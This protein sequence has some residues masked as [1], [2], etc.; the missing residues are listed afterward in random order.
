MYVKN[1]TILKNFVGVIHPFEQLFPPI[2]K[3]YFNL[4]YK[5]KYNINPNAVFYQKFKH[6]GNLS[7]LEIR[8]I[9]N[10]ESY[11]KFS[12]EF[13]LEVIL[14]L[15]SHKNEHEAII[16]LESL[17]HKNLIVPVNR[18]NDTEE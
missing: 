2:I 4:N 16:A 12:E 17:I 9:N 6:S 14:N 5:N 7:A 1:E 13:Y 11:S 10:I 8:I 18:Y 3:N 15:I